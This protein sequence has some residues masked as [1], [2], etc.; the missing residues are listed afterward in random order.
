MIYLLIFLP[1]LLSFVSDDPIIVYT[2]SWLGSFWIFYVTW[3]SPFR[4]IKTDLPIAQQIMRPLFLLQ[5]IFAGFMC[6]TSIFYFIDAMGYRYFEKVNYLI[7]YR[8]LELTAV[9]Q[10]YSLLGHAALVSGIIFKQ[11]DKFVSGATYRFKSELTSNKLIQL[12]I[13]AFLLATLFSVIPSLFQFSL[14]LTNLSVILSAFLITNGVLKKSNTL[15]FGA[16]IFGSNFVKAS[17]SGF[18]EPILVSVIIM[19]VMFYPHYKRLVIMLSIPAIYILLYV[20]PTYANIVRSQSWSGQKT[21]VEAREEAISTILSAEEDEVD[22]TNWG[23]LTNRLSEINMFTKFAKSTPEKIDYYGFDIFVQSI[24]SIFPRALW[25]DKPNIEDLSMQ[26]VYDA[27]VVSKDSAV[28]A[29]TRPIVDAYLSFGSIGIVIFLFFYGWFTQFLCNH[30]ERLFG[31]YEIGCMII[32][33]GLFQQMWRGNNSE[34][35]V[36]SVFWGA[37]MMIFLF[38]VMKSNGLLVKE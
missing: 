33:N 8:I 32:F 12:S 13:G 3:F 17:L 6:C 24:E 36:N 23:F 30:S 9:C 26:R 29:K 37:V 18:K 5:L 25:P 31:G 19:A 2:I 7:D 11:S 15:V 22:N 10:R 21:A 1:Y 35:L 4:M 14:F 34:F 16:V 38:R 20:L 28:S 27:E